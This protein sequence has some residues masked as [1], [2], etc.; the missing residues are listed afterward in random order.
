[1]RD[2]ELYRALPELTAPWTVAAVAMWTWRRSAGGRG[3][4]VRDVRAAV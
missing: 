1:M 2:I 4:G 3:A